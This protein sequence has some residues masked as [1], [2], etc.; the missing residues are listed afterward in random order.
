MVCT[1]QQ[2]QTIIHFY[3]AKY[4]AHKHIEYPLLAIGTILALP[5]IAVG[6]VLLLVA[7]FCIFVPIF[8]LYL[9]LTSN[10]DHNKD[11]DEALAINRD[12]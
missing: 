5:F 7:Y 8:Y 1:L 9:Y 6:A 12:A 2:K 11:I 10:S 3:G 4:M